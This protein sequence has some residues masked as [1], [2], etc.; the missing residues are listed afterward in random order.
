MV[1]TYA[2]R[3]QLPDD[4]YNEFKDLVNAGVA[5]GTPDE[6]AEIYKQ[7][8]QKDYDYAIAIRLAVAT[9]RHYEQRWVKGYYYNPIY[10]FSSNWM[11]FSKD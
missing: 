11:R 10:G 9:G 8:G 4:M 3:Q 6:R 5:A 1:G 7:L 2:A